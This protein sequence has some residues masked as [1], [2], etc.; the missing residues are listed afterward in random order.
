MKSPILCLLALLLALSAAATHAAGATRTIAVNAGLAVPA[1]DLSDEVGSGYLVGATYCHQFNDRFG[2]GIDANYLALGEKAI[3][4]IAK[5]RLRGG[6][7]SLF[8][9]Y[10]LPVKDF[11]VAPYV[12]FGLYNYRLGFKTTT[13][14]AGTSRESTSKRSKNGIG[15]GAG[16]IRKLD[17]RSSVGLELNYSTINADHGSAGLFSVGLSYRYR[18]GKK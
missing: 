12:K 16:A 2:L 14:I 17:D 3:S 15:I 11:P 8:G 1:G 13:T 7:G 10:M 9:R 5:E 6:Q 18:I 4:S